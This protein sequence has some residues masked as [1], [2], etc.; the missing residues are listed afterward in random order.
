M[1][2]TTLDA[3]F[4]YTRRGWRVIPIPTRSKNPNRPGWQ[5]ER[6]D[7]SDLPD[8]FSNGQNIGVLMGEPSGGLVDV[9]LDR[10][11]VRQLAPKYLPETGAIFGR[12]SSPASHWLYACNTDTKQHS[13]PTGWD[14]GEDGETVI[15]IRSTGG[16]TV[17]PGSTHVEGEPITWASEGE[18]A[19]VD[20]TALQEAVQGL[21]AAAILL[22]AIKNALAAI[23]PD[24]AY[25]PW[26]KVGMALHSW[27]NEQGLLVWDEWSSRAE[28]KY[29]GSTELEG[30]WKSFDATGGVHLGTLF[31]LAEESGWTRLPKLGI[32]YHEGQPSPE[33]EGDPAAW[34][35]LM[36]FASA[37]YGPPIPLEVF[38]PVLAD[39]IA[40]VALS[41]QVPVELPAVLA[42]CV[43]AAAGAKRFEVCVGLTHREPLN[44]YG[45]A[46]LDPGERKSATFDELLLPL[47]EY[48]AQL[49]E[50]AAPEIAKKAEERQCQDAR[51]VELRRKAAKAEDRSEAA[52]LKQ[53]AI[54]LASQLIEVPPSPRLICGDTTSEAMAM[55]LAGH[56]GR[57]LQADAEGGAF[58]NIIGGGYTKNGATSLDVHL[59]AHAGDAIRVDRATRPALSVRKPALTTMLTAQP[60]LLRRIKCVDELRERG[61]LARF[62]FILPSPMVGHRTFDNIPMDPL[63]S[64]AF[65]KLIYYLSAM[66]PMPDDEPRPLS[67]D[68]AAWEVW[69]DYAQRVEYQLAEGG[70]LA[71]LRDWGAKSSGLVARLSGILHL[72]SGGTTGPISPATV[73]AAVV[74]VECF[75]QHACAAYNLLGG[76]KD[77]MARR[78][79]GWIRRNK[80]QR[81]T[82]HQCFDCL[83]RGMDTGATTSDLERPLS[84]LESRNYIRLV[85]VPP[86]PRRAGRP[87]SP[88]F[89]V[90]PAILEGEP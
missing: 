81:F 9:D 53:D 26:I 84:I 24:C 75:T 52:K 70:S 42:L 58:F 48:E 56:G 6:W 69:H 74:C 44:I 41:K 87:P 31:H 85:A 13:L 29:T 36:P 40:S 28:R 45:L 59:K 83:R 49:I 12:K 61:L 90:N 63:A 71:T 88:A 35:P 8:L 10:P 46:L 50:A 57:M 5:T 3:A 38:P 7:E 1:S 11:E 39:H 14:G 79:L 18:P 89:E 77:E 55:L 80:L 37:E 19:Q 2:T 20:G 65:A 51:L 16:Q 21:H 27:D 78:A 60:D 72:A 15:E 73:A 43:V 47:T 67:I 33:S 30:H 66:P 34:G 32:F 86:G 54:D 68:G 25:A 22:F 17:F 82:M 76:A 4:A 64:A 62:T 23:P